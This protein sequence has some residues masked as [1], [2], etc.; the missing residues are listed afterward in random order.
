MGNGLEKTTGMVLGAH[1]EWV[2]GWRRLPEWSE[3]S[4]GMGYGLEKT[5]GMVS[6]LTGDGLRIGEERRNGL[7]AHRGWGYGLETVV[8]VGRGCRRQLPEQA[9]SPEA[10]RS[11]NNIYIYIYI[12]IYI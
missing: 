1:Q 11:G 10:R 12:Y 5:A 9:R 7:G 4:L 2:T 8:A 6:E 3:S